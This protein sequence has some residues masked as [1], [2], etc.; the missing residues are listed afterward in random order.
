[1]NAIQKKLVMLNQAWMAYYDNFGS[2]AAFAAQVKMEE[3][4]RV[5]KNQMQYAESLLD[6]EIEYV[7][8]LSKG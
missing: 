5:I 7:N 2:G 4:S 8:G 1:M 3:F 6:E